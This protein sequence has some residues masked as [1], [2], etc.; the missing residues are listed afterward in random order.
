MAEDSGGGKVS[1]TEDA[2]LDVEISCTRNIEQLELFRND[3]LTLQVFVQHRH[4]FLHF[5]ITLRRGFISRQNGI[6]ELET[7]VFR[8]GENVL[9]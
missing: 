9:C 3:E 1:E 8:F 2:E 6:V 7:G 4:E 5:F